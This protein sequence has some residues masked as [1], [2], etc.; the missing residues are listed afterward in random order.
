MTNGE[1]DK[2][3]EMNG[4][5][6][7]LESTVNHFKETWERQDEQATE[8]RR[9]LYDKFE[10][11]AATVIRMGAKVEQIGTEVAALKPQV[12]VL[13]Q[14]HQQ[15]LGSKKVVAAVWAA[16]FTLA[17]TAGA[18]AIKLLELFWPPKH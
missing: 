17:G 8:G 9:R 1:S 7:G 13:D 18:A 5:I 2:L 12:V 3:H 4:R 10:E 6:S 16:I 11:L 15:G 14:H